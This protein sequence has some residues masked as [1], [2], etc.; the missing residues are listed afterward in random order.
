MRSKIPSSRDISHANPIKQQTSPS[1]VRAGGNVGKPAHVT[2]GYTIPDGVGYAGSK[3]AVQKGRRNPISA[4][5][6]L[7]SG[8]FRIWVNHQLPRKLA[9]VFPRPARSAASARSAAT[10]LIREITPA[11]PRAA[12]LTTLKVAKPAR[13]GT[14]RAFTEMLPGIAGRNMSI[15]S[16]VE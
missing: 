10:A 1:C 6:T 9:G 8:S 5:C 11:D 3:I 7:R 12:S 2:A 13:N 16:L 15:R 4:K 14:H